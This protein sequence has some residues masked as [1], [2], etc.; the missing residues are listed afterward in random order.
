MAADIRCYP[1]VFRR[2]FLGKKYDVSAAWLIGR[3]GIDEKSET[4]ALAAPRAGS[5]RGD[6]SMASTDLIA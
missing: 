3:S 1:A 4:H 6:L 5:C 2:C